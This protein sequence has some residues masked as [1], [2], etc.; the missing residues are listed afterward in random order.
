MSIPVWPSTL[1]PILDR[2]GYAG[3]APDL[4]L[5]TKMDVGMAKVRRRVSNNVI[6]VSG[7]LVLDLDQLVTLLAFHTTTT[8]GG[9][10][11]FSWTDP[12][13]DAA[14]EMMFVDPPTYVGLGAE[15]FDATLKLEIMP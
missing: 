12:L 11:R 8:L 3:A 6:P 5:R 13:T 7:K 9:S 14:V 10:L 2:E 1:P 15:L 4:A